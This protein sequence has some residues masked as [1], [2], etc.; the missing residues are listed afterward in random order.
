M[1]TYTEIESYL[2]LLSNSTLFMI[3]FILSMSIMIYEGIRRVVKLCQKW[4]KTKEL[5]P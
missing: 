3:L 4:K 2:H 1:N 5:Y